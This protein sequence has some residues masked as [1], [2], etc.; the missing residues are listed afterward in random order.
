[1]MQSQ[2]E[3]LESI[4]KEYKLSSLNDGEVY[5]IQVDALKDMIKDVISKAYDENMLCQYVPPGHYDCEKQYLKK[6]TLSLSL[7]EPYNKVNNI[8]I[9]KLVR[10]LSGC[11][12]KQA[13]EVLKSLP[14]DFFTSCDDTYISKTKDSF[15]AIGVIV[16][17]RSETV[18]S[19]EE[20]KFHL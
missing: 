14:C 19:F 7:P 2:Q 18:E 6:L 16:N 20:T 13:K 1:M 5:T 15:E 4:L 9:M 3:L 11:T 8:F 10:E 12:L 17:V